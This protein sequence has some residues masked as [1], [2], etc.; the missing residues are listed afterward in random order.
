MCFIS[1]ILIHVFYILLLPVSFLYLSHGEE[2][3]IWRL[4][5]NMEEEGHDAHWP[6]Q[7]DHRCG[8][9]HLNNLTDAMITWKGYTMK[10][11]LSFRIADENQN[12]TKLYKTSVKTDGT[13]V[14]LYFI[15]LRDFG[16]L[17]ATFC[18]MTHSVEFTAGRR[19]LFFLLC[20]LIA[21]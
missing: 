13:F 1:L 11:H 16:A 14:Y 18:C 6:T 2:S 7:T 10:L 8:T 4:S 19:H 21:K 12:I 17:Q 3:I 20:Y 9:T 5:V 15:T